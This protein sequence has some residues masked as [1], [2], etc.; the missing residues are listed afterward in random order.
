MPEPT[1]GVPVG[2][3]RSFRKIEVPL[4]AAEDASREFRDW[5][6]ISGA[7]GVLLG[8]GGGGEGACCT[9]GAGCDGVRHIDGTVL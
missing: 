3:V 9:T 5:G 7:V 2:I 4:R 1:D 8:G 6:S